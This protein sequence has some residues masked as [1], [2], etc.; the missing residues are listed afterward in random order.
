[1]PSSGRAALSNQPVD[2]QTEEGSNAAKT[3]WSTDSCYQRG[4]GEW[5]KFPPNSLSDV[6][7][8]LTYSRCR[9]ADFLDENESLD[10]KSALNHWCRCFIKSESDLN[11]RWT[12]FTSEGNFVVEG[13]FWVNWCYIAISWPSDCSFIQLRS[14]CILSPFDWREHDHWLLWSLNK[15]IQTWEKVLLSELKSSLGE[16]FWFLNTIGFIVTVL[17]VQM[18]R[19]P[20]VLTD[21]NLIVPTFSNKVNCFLWLNVWEIAGVC[22]CRV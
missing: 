8:S 7:A 9:S 12:L 14:F 21:N 15:Q 18:F 6:W 22:K 19:R 2:W 16:I 17:S 5:N 4:N 3:L 10:I 13:H 11:L 1:M 20:Y